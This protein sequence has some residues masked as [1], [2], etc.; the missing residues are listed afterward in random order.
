MN[1]KDV[2]VDVSTARVLFVISTFRYGTVI[3]SNATHW[4]ARYR[5]HVEFPLGPCMN[6]VEPLSGCPVPVPENGLTL[7]RGT[8]ICFFVTPSYF[9]GTISALRPPLSGNTE[10]SAT[11]NG[12]ATSIL[13]SLSLEAPANAL[14]LDLESV[15]RLADVSEEQRLGAEGDFAN[16]GDVDVVSA[17]TKLGVFLEDGAG[18]GNVNNIEVESPVDSD[19]SFGMGKSSESEPP[20]ATNI[21]SEVADASL[22]IAA[23]PFLKV[24]Y[25]EP[26]YDAFNN[27][28]SLPVHAVLLWGRLDSQAC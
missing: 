12:P 8:N 7:S 23:Y 4:A 9:G 1:H 19:S 22:Q 6:K 26:Y 13:T 28:R 10:S 14:N 15:A 18:S 27:S 16:A 11:H 21:D 25:V 5:L 20:F 2:T 17:Y 3:H 24:P